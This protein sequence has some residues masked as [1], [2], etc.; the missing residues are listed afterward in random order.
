[1][2]KS[3]QRALQVFKDGE[4]R[5]VFCYSQNTRDIVTTDNH[6]K[7]LSAKRDLTWFKNKFGNNVFREEGR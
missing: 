5:Y 3:N 6:G 2:L 7:A 1:M 4:W